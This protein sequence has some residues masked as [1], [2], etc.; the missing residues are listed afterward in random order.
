M[1]SWILMGKEEKRKNYPVYTRADDFSRNLVEEIVACCNRKLSHNPSNG[2][3]NE[4]FLYNYPDIDLLEKI[5]AEM[6][7]QFSQHDIDIPVLLFPND[8]DRESI[9]LTQ[10][11]GRHYGIDVGWFINNGW[12]VPYEDNFN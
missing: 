2:K 11:K 7:R 12:F 10:E 9:P 6:L 1:I 5:K 8:L 4:I 3:Y